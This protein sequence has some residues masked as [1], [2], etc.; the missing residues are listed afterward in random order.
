MSGNLFKVSHELNIGEGY[1]CTA[2]Y[3][4]QV[5]YGRFDIGLNYHKC[6]LGLNGKCYHEDCSCT[7]DFEFSIDKSNIVMLRSQND[8][9]KLQAT[10]SL[11]KTTD[12]NWEI[13]PQNSDGAKL[14][15]N[16]SLNN[17]LDNI[18]QS[19][20]IYV[21]AGDLLGEYLITARL[22]DYPEIFATSTLTVIDVFC[23]P[24]CNEIDPDYGVI[25]PAYVVKGMDSMFKAWIEPKSIVTNS[26]IN[27]LWVT[28]NSNITISK[29][30]FGKIDCAWQW[31]GR[32]FSNIK[33]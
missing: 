2:S 23:E 15:L 27:T 9:V 5:D 1:Y 10:H 8:L 14:H 22:N 25:N 29:Q 28:S 20:T 33:Y 7:K 19:D 18:Y 12:I 21:S 26:G 16:N 17:G 13:T 32:M 31:I 6:S 4:D 3:D 24:I 30:F 11:S